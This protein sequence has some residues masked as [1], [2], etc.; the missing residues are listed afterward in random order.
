MFSGRH[1]HYICIHSGRIHR[2]RRFSLCL[3]LFATFT[4]VTI[5]TFRPDRI[6]SIADR[7]GVDGNM[8][9]ENIL[10]GDKF[11]FEPIDPFL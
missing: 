7:F 8:A 9:L 6:R 3:P 5:G 1:N 10:Y 11:R 4:Q 2:H